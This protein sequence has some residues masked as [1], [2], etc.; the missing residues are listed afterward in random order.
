MGGGGS[1]AWW[2]RQGEGQGAICGAITVFAPLR[3]V[4]R[5]IMITNDIFIFVGNDDELCFKVLRGSSDNVAL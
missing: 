2:G 3:D 1:R 4:L 5:R